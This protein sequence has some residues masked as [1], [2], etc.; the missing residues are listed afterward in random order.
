MQQRRLGL[1]PVGR[2]TAPRLEHG[3]LQRAAEGEAQLPRL[4]TCAV[5]RVQPGGGLLVRLPP[6]Q[7]HDARHGCRDGLAQHGDR[8]LGDLR[9]VHLPGAVDAGQDH[10]RLEERVLQPDTVPPE[11][12]VEDGEDLGGRLGTP[13][14]VVGTRH[15]HLR[16]DDGRETGLLGERG[17]PRQRVCVRLRARGRRQAVPDPQHRTPLGEPRPERD[18]LLQAAT[19]AV[20]AL[21]H[22]LVREPGERRHPPV[23]LDPR[24]DAP[25]REDLRERRA[26]LR[27]LPQRLVEEDDAADVLLDAGAGEQQLP[28]GA[29]KLLRRLQPDRRQSLGDRREAL[30]GGQDAL[31]GRHEL[32][33]R[34][35][36]RPHQVRQDSARLTVTFCGSDADSTTGTLTSRTPSR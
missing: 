13:V 14:Q 3:C 18:V 16:L 2:L 25:P 9:V 12:V 17:V 34:P 31:P 15:Q 32:V 19:Q 24:D 33:S 6:G 10:V 28:V 4:A 22:H 11:L 20:E 29:T 1:L 8:R 30:V 36:H 35:A 5:E 7:E 27:A 21:G 23:D 26:V